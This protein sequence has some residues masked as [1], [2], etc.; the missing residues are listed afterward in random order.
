MPKT[1]MI[2]DETYNRLKRMKEAKGMSF[3]K[4]LDGLLAKEDWKTLREKVMGFKGTG[5]ADKDEVADVERIL[6][7]GWKRWNKRYA[8]TRM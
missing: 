1:I 2:A 4:L 6:K 5:V 7:E 8:S 3:T